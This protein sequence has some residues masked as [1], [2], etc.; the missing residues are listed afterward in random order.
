[1]G[2]ASFMSARPGC[3][4]QVNELVDVETDMTEE[5]RKATDSWTTEAHGIRR[6]FEAPLVRRNEERLQV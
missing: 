3:S 2:H 4:D 6:L 5:L 1:M